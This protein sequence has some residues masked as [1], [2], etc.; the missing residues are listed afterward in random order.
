MEAK[1]QIDYLRTI[2]N[3]VIEIRSILHDQADAEARFI[4]RLQSLEE[5]MDQMELALD[6]LLPDGE[7]VDPPFDV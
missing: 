7:G 4:E 6:S 1:N 3:H 2:S 5:R